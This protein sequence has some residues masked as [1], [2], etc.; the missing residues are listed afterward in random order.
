MA[1]GLVNKNALLANVS[2]IQFRQMPRSIPTLRLKKTAHE[3]GDEY[4]RC[5][6]KASRSNTDLNDCIQAG[7][8]YL[9]ALEGLQ[10]H[11]ATLRFDDEV[12]H[13][14][15]NTKSYIDLVQRELKKFES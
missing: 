2:G 11:L 14:I 13:L 10:T 15:K 8:S 9:E 6:T 3:L 12:D 7:R 5:V 1:R 4:Y